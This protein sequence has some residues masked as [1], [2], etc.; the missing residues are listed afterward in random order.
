MTTKKHWVE[1]LPEAG[2]KMRK[3]GKRVLEL[4]QQ[5][6]ALLEEAKLINEALLAEARKHWSEDELKMAVGSSALH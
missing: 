2:V 1:F 3:D 6:K 5:A 4:E